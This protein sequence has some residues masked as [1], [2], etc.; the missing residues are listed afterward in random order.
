MH[1]FLKNPLLALAAVLI[2]NLGFAQDQKNESSNSKAEKSEDIIIRKKG[3]K[4][5][6]MTIVV[7]G[8]KVTINGKPADDLKNDDVTVL[9]RDHSN[10]VEPGVRR[11]GRGGPAFDNNNFNQFRHP[12]TNKAMLGILT[13]KAD[14]G[15]K[16]TDVTKESSA[17]KAG[18]KKE[19]V[20]TRAGDADIKT[21]QDL[22]AA[23]SKYKPNDKVDITYN[24]NGKT[25][26]TTAILGENKKDFAFNFNT[27]DINF[28]MPKDALQ[29]IENFNFNFDGKPK[30]GLQIQDIEEGKGVKVKDVDNDSPAAKAGMKEGDVIT[31]VNGKSIAGVDELRNE[32]KDAKDGDAIKFAYK[33]DGKNQT[34]EI[35]IPK[36]LK[37]ADL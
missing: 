3:D 6:K 30:I 28:N 31:Q 34:A 35:K 26:K 13:E 17:E 12:N 21:P 18:L 27:D 32:I 11:F 8:D 14:N 7:E 2:V 9:R 10:T 36:K 25:N 33:R 23:I 37:S 29:R 20:I 16:V 15:V 4:T 1:K 22:I 24:R 19:D 5:E